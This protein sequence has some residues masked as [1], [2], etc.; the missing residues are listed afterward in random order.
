MK[1]FLFAIIVLASISMSSNVMAQR[2][3]GEGGQRGQ[4]G[5]QR[6][7]GPGG[8]RG[9]QRGERPV[10]P[11]MTALDADKDGKL[12][13]DEIKNAAVALKALDKN[14]DGVLDAT[15]MAPA[16]P[17]RG[18]RGGAGG[19]AGGGAP[20]ASAFVDRMME[21]D[22]DGDGV[23]T[24]EEGGDQMARFFDRLDTD[25]DGKLT[26]T[27]IEEMAKRFGGGRGGRGGGRGGRGGGGGQPDSKSNR[28]GFD[29][30]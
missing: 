17:E 24:K 30:K 10:S 7:G 21:R 5:G 23:I 22:T 18:G 2:G 19:G 28:P 1:K 25:G 8:Q 26:K 14:N 15:E 13:A 16:R 9:G 3:G 11:L 4:R 29:D 6:G 20:N 27:E 12:S